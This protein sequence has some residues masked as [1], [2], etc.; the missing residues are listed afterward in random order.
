MRNYDNE[1]TF[2]DAMMYAMEGQSP[3]KAIENQEKRGQAD[4]VR[5]QRLPKRINDNSLS[6][7]IYWKGVTSDMDYEERLKIITRNRTEYTKAQYEKM[8]I[9]I[10]GEYD[11][12]FWNVTLPDGWEIKATE[13]SMWNDLYDDK[14]RKRANFFYKAAFY[15]RDAFINFCTRFTVI[16]EHT[17][18]YDADYEVWKA[19]DYQGKI[20]DGD[21]IIYCTECV[22]PIGTYSG[23]D[24]IKTHLRDKVVSFIEEHY[25]NYKDINAYWD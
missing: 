24:V 11:D 13:H 16:V 10:I 12:L 9:K 23:D 22:P 2:L 17:A 7:D 8:G 25:P 21:E 19:S 18:P 1:I 6:H 14:G 4:V 15:D 20:K 5:N 3:S